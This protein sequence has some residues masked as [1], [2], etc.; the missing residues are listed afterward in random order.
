MAAHEPCV[1]QTTLLAGRAEGMESLWP[2]GQI[3]IIFPSNGISCFCN[4]SDGEATIIGEQNNVARA[5]VL[6]KLPV[7]STW[8]I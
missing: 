3:Q 5:F 6:Q 4:D 7:Y 8:K 1:S 2:E